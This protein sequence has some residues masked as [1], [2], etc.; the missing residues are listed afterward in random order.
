MF[1]AA[2]TTD[3]GDPLRINTKI[4][5]QNLRTVYKPQERDKTVNSKQLRRTVSQVVKV[6]MRNGHILYGKLIEYNAYNF[7]MNVNGQLVL[8]YKHAIYEFL[9]LKS[10]PHF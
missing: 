6:T 4:E 1:S 3:L 5:A 7:T 8:I 9:V 2:T 10:L